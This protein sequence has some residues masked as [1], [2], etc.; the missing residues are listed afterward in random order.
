VRACYAEG[1]KKR[2]WA[3]NLLVLPVDEPAGPDAMGSVVDRD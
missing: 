3:P 1:R 2:Q